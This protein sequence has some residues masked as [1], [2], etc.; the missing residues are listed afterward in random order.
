MK[1]TRAI[2]PASGWGTRRLPITKAIEK[3]MLPV[4]N[5]PLVD[6]VVEDCLKAG[7][8][9]IYFMV[10]QHGQQLKDYY[11]TNQEFEQFLNRRGQT[12]AL[13][14]IQPPRQ[15]SFHYIPAQLEDGRYGTSVPVGLAR[16]QIPPGESAVVVM[17]DD[18]IYHP[19]ETSEVARLLGAAAGGNSAMLGV[20]MATEQL[21][22]YG[23]IELTRQ[24]QFKR[25]IERPA[26]GE[27]PSNL[28]NVS[29]YIMNARLLDYVADHLNETL[30]AGQEH[31]IIEPINR[32]VAAGGQL[33]VLPATGEYLD[34]GTLAGW[35]H[36]NQVVSRSR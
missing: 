23:V 29:K 3:S 35:L 33:T 4:G 19:D 24:Q 5:R 21:S 13:A 32:Y 14:L 26:S 11:G 36:A 25:I 2:I 7:I 18:F 12:E 9:T 20:E 27:A 16:P 1:I 22:S 31:Q 34:G 8:T 15:V 10:G 17:S 6:Y 28:I 30:P